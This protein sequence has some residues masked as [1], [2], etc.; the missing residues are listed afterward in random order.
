M[1]MYAGTC[2]RCDGPIHQGDEIVV[3]RHRIRT[4]VIHA[5]CASGQGDE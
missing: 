4:D 2:A 3:R 5:R 1:A